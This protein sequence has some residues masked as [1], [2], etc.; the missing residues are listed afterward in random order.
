M[1]SDTTS[2][3]TAVQV[4][5]ELQ[6]ILESRLFAPAKRLSRFLEYVVDAALEGAEV[7][8]SVIGV[9]VY[10]REP[11]YD[12]KTDSIVRAEASRLRAKLREYYE[13]DGRASAL[14]IELPKGGYQ[15]A[16]QVLPEAELAARRRLWP[17]LGAAV[18]ALVGAVLWWN[19]S[20]PGRTRSIAVATLTTDSGDAAV[21]SLGGSLSSELR[22]ALLAS[23]RWKVTTLASA[24]NV[25]RRNQPVPVGAGAGVEVVLT[26][27]LR[28]GEKGVVNV[29]LQL[30][31]AA[32]GYLLW[33]GSYRNP[34][35]ILNESQKDLARRVA[36]EILH[37]VAG[38]RPP[39]RSADY[40]RARELANS[41]AVHGA[42]QSAALF[43]RAI[44][45]DPLF[46]P[47][48]AGLAHV[49]LHLADLSS[50]M[51]TPTRIEAARAAARKA[52]A[53]DESNAEAHTVL[54]QIYL[55]RDWNF[56]QAVLELRRAVVLDPVSIRPAL[57]YS[58]ALT[59]V[60][61]FA[62]AEDAISA[63]RTRLPDNAD[64]LF[65][66]G[67]VYFMGHKFEKM[68]AIGRELIAL[69]PNRA[70][71]YW[72]VGV[73]LEQR[74]SVREAIATFED[75][76]RQAPTNDHR[77]MCAL[78]HSFAL[79]GDRDRAMTIVRRYTDLKA[80]TITRYSLPYCVAVTYTALG[81][82]DLAFQWLEK[83]RDAGDNSFPFFPFDPRFDKFR[84]DPRYA[85]LRASLNSKPKQSQ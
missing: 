44:Q 13:S 5:A 31:S 7:K 39:A 54:G 74:G 19:S 30:V 11:T 59:M 67:A 23:K 8:E 4:R 55:H 12:P 1:I 61:D 57:S 42:E 51:D 25:S 47:A 58:E 43:E 41:N 16:F 50:D 68:E 6:R 9:A 21:A 82:R 75:G 71:G 15:P 63:A 56:P 24:P 10:G 2:P 84:E 73:S 28:R 66:E 53:L 36:E 40:S 35:D 81:E 27:D 22:D 79:A 34:V 78:G 76:L 62:G 14:R 20:Q 18:L 17:W 32:D 69:Q 52:I 49:T 38:L 48:W 60:G 80:K 33:T 45:S 29:D 85:K 77:T 37:K 83:A 64:L 65:Q 72:L 46:S 3:P 26:G 70:L